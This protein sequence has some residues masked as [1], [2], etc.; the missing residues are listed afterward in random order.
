MLILYVFLEIL[1]FPFVLIYVLTGSNTRKSFL[2]RMGIYLPKQRETILFHTVSVGEF[3]AARNLIKKIMEENKDIFVSTVTL[4]GR[5]MV[6]KEKL[7]HIFFPFDFPIIV[8]RFLDSLNPKVVFIFETEIW[9]YFI[10]KCSKKKIPLIIINGRISDKSF[11]RYKKL[12]FFFKPFFEKIELVLAQSKE[13]AERFEVLGAKKVKVCG[14]LKFD[15][16]IKEIPEEIRKIYDKFVEGR[17]GW[18]AGSTLK[19][20]EEIILKAHKEILKENPGFFLILAPRHP[21][22]AQEV[23]KIISDFDL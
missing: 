9:P 5:E 3:L 21:E 23:E 18:V 20:E 16:K 13:D 15:I 22:R 8:E 11:K 6:L 10:F 7:P 4:T 12:S 2:F 19:G 14:N 1:L 17:E